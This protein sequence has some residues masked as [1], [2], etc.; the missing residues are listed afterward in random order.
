MFISWFSFFFNTKL[1]RPGR[2]GQPSR[3]GSG[4]GSRA[5]SILLHLPS[6]WAAR[7]PASWTRA[8]APTSEVR[9]PGLPGSAAPVRLEP[10]ARPGAR[11]LALQGATPEVPADSLL[12]PPPSTVRSP[13]AG[14]GLAGGHGAF[15][16]SVLPAGGQLATSPGRGGGRC[17]QV[18][19]LG[20]LWEAPPEGWEKQVQATE[21]GTTPVPPLGPPRCLFCTPPQ[22]SNTSPSCLY[23]SLD[24]VLSPF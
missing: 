22:P 23:L 12:H 21:W 7:P 2:P 1:Q 20:M 11:A 9:P 4:P 5:L 8:S 10:W 14:A 15:S 13:P 18:S 3:R 6:P 19:G 16:A 24:S 17:S